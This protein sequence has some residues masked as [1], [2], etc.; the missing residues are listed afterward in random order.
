MFVFKKIIKVKNHRISEESK[1]SIENG[2]LSKII[3]R[4]TF[5]ELPLEQ[6]TT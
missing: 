2:L 6:P 1:N 5:G 4:F 3:E